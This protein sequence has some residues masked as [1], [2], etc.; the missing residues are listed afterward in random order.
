MQVSLKNNARLYIFPL[1][2]VHIG[3]SSFNEELFDVWCEIFRS[4]RGEKIIYLMGDLLETPTSKFSSYDINMNTNDAMEYL[5]RKLKPFRDFIRCS[6]SGNH[7]LRTSREFDYDISREISERLG[8]PHSRNDFFDEL[9]INGNSFVVYG[10]H[11]VRT[12]KS[13]DLAMKNFKQDCALK[14]FDLALQGH[15]HMLKFDSE[16]QRTI[17]GGR[18]KYYAFTGHYLQYNDSYA[19]NKQYP[20][21]PAGFQKIGV[22]CDGKCNS[23]FYHVDDFT[24]EVI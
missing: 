13:N 18:R 21:S 20:V 11:G 22:D 2:D 10:L 16:Y 19:N 23:Q 14:E 15:N 6:C 3:N 4:C 24:D 1:S 17:D 5:I 12:S 8:V 9:V 7:E